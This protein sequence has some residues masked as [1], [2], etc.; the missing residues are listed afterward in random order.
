[1]S[2]SNISRRALTPA[3]TRSWVSPGGARAARD[4]HDR[5]EH[6]RDRHADDDR[7]GGAGRRRACPPAR[8]R[9]RASAATAPAGSA[10][11]SPSDEHRADDLRARRA[12]GPGQRHRRAAAARGEHRDQGQGPDRDERGPQRDHRDERRRGLP[13]RPMAL[14]DRQHAGPQRR[15]RWPAVMLADGYRTWSRRK[16]VIVRSRVRSRSRSGSRN[17]RHV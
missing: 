2:A 4:P 6:D 14:E 11:R 16:P 8:A 1:M 7:D 9:S 10:M 3:T 5:R 15:C 13:P 17:E 12:A